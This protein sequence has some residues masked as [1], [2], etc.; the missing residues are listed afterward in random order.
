[1]RRYLS[2]LLLTFLL[3]SSQAASLAPVTV[4]GQRVLPAGPP[5]FGLNSHLA[6][7][8]LNL[9]CVSE[10]AG[11]V[12]DLGL[13]WVREDLHWHRVQP[14]PDTWDWEYTDKAITEL[15]Q[16]NLNILG[17]L[18]PS[19]G[20]ATSFPN[21]LPN[22]VSFYPPDLD[23][24]VAYTRATVSRYKEQIHY[25]EVWNE[26]DNPWFWKPTPDPRA[27]A[28]LL[29]RT[30]A[31]IRE[32]DPSAKILMGGFNP[33]DTAFL[34]QMMAANVW[35]SFDILAIHPYVDPC[36]PEEGNIAAAPGLVR[37]LADQLG[38][39]PIW[40]T[41]IGWSSGPGDRDNKGLTDERMQANF[42]VRALLLLWE[43]GVE[44]SFW[45][46]LKDDEHNPYG[47]L[48]FGTGRN[49]FSQR[50]PAFAA[51][52]TLNRELQGVTFSEK[53]DLFQK[54]VIDNFSE[55]RDWRRVSQPNG[56]LRKTDAG[57]AEL[58]YNFSTQ[59]NDYV[60][61]ERSQ[62]LP[63]VGEPYGLGL[64]VYGD[65]SDQTL[66]VWVKDAEGEVLQFVLG[67]VGAPRWHTI[68]TPIVGQVEPG[69]R[70]SGQ[71]NGKIDF[72]ASVVALVLDDSRDSFVGFG[73]V[74]LDNLTAI[75][76]REVYDLR[77]E[78][79]NKALD[80][81]WSPPGIRVTLNTTLPT[82]SI[83]T[84]AGARQ[85]ITASKGQFL[86]NVGPDPLYL[87]HAR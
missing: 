61:F 59:E 5:S 41:E 29:R 19:V 9:A 71:G 24:F 14:Q 46:T 25:W 58:N 28:E 40:A 11:M 50:K 7:R 34:R 57:N 4:L 26:P 51:F 42:L 23:R 47:L 2:F 12:A 76:G 52:Q 60:A 45:Y 55:V 86:L 63:L 53:R 48:A 32:V 54:K 84:R 85:P 49:D 22:D 56:T 44:R 64:D 65:G 38:P 80:V 1:M 13:A 3:V 33:F 37:A 79:G 75:S 77:F 83:V 78:R 70:I 17:V 73:Q 81:I 43:G 62:P 39:K 68:T 31:A 82:G 67:I 72:P 20:W 21:D 8:C 6:T 36:G 18:G 69:N 74:Y 87:W 35:D 66:K 15:R 27:Y 30:S 16:R 10:G